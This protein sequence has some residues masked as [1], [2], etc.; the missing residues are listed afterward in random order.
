[1]SKRIMNKVFSC[2]DDC[3]VKTDY[4]YTDS[5]NLKY[6]DVD[7]VVKGYKDKY[8]LELV[9]EELGKFHIDF[10]MDNANSEIYAIES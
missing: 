1:M 4:Q 3:N 7:K 8:G 5:T 10:S 9:G 2:A 6:D